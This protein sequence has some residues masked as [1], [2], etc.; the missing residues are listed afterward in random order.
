MTEPTRPQAPTYDGEGV[1]TGMCLWEAMLALAN[2]A[3]EEGDEPMIDEDA[4]EHDGA[5]ETSEAVDVAVTAS[6]MLSDHG[7]FTVRS[8][9]VD[10]IKPC[11]EAWAAER[12]AKGDDAG[13]FDWDWC[14]AFLR[15]S[16]L[17][18]SMEEALERQYRP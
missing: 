5:G 9:L 11:E 10:L 8:A 2:P 12:E 17:D 1:V 3:E 7:S 14:P 4:D 6:D 18:G 16:I 13:Q 15:Q